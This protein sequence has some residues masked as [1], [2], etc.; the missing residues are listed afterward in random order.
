MTAQQQ[1]EHHLTEAGRSGTVVEVPAWAV[2][3]FRYFTV[4]GKPGGFATD[5]A[6]AWVDGRGAWDQLL[7]ADGPGVVARGLAGALGEGRIEPLTAGSP[8]VVALPDGVK[9]QVHDPS[10]VRATDG[11]VRFLA[12]YAVPPGPNITRLEV[13][14]GTGGKPAVFERIPVDTLV[15]A[16]SEVEVWITKLATETGPSRVTLVKSL[17]A[18]KDPRAVAALIPVLADKWV[19]ARKAAATALEQLGDG[20]AVGPLVTAA[21]AET[22]PGAGIAMVAAIAKLGGTAAKT[23]LATLAKD[24]PNELVRNR[25]RYESDRL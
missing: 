24:H 23:P 10:V 21:S 8:A 2:G 17:G 20:G 18:S 3:S 1:L 4:D 11:T 7:L 9:A 13:R 14:T 16:G 25:A 5:T 19:D 6:V 12:F 15:P 22:D